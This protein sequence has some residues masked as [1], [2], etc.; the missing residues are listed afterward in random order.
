MIAEEVV[1]AISWLDNWWTREGTL[2]VLLCPPLSPLLV[3]KRL[4]C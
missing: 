3:M 1:V 4:W 2:M